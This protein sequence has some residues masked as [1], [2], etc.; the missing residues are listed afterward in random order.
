MWIYLDKTGSVIMH[1]DLYFVQIKAVFTDFKPLIFSKFIG[2][3]QLKLRVNSHNWNIRT[4][5]Y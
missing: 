2:L 3:K 1:I 5:L 4:N